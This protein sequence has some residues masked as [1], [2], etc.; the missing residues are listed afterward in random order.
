MTVN[1]TTVLSELV[2]ALQKG[3][4]VAYPTEAVFGVGCDP[5][6]PHAIAALLALKQRSVEKGLILIAAEYQQLKPYI[7]ETQLT[8]DRLM[9]IQHTWPGPVTWVMP[10]KQG[11]STWLTGQFS[12][13]AVRVSAHPDVQRLCQAF[14]KPIT[15]TSANLSGLPPCKTVEQVRAQ[16]ASSPL[17]LMEGVVGGREN[18]SEIRDALTGNVFRQ[19]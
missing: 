4:V 5:D 6:N 12:S 9:D 18:P 16:F 13:I 14:G 11:V 10:A 17:L 8:P 7:D 3:N 19:G 1:S 2:M 15:S